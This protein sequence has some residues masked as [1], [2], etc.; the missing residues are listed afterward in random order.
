[1]NDQLSVLNLRDDYAEASSTSDASR[2]ALEMPA[3]MEVFVT[4]K[5]AAHEET[6]QARLLWS[7]Y[8][9]APPSLKFRDPVTGGDDSIYLRRGRNAAGFDPLRWMP[10]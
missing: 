7:R 10:A 6:Y 5:P 4:L 1:M 9:D 3:D 8:P 2:W